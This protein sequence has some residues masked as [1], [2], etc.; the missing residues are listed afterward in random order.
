MAALSYAAIAL[1]LPLLLDCFRS[2][3][4]MMLEKARV[5]VYSEERANRM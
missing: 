4:R 1:I 3:C 5:F 2:P